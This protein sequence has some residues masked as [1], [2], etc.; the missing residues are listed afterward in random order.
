MTIERTDN[1]IVNSLDKNQETKLSFIS[2]SSMF[3]F[4]LIDSL[5]KKTCLDI[6]FSFIAGR[7]KTDIIMEKPNIKR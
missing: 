2:I 1:L 5:I 4:K 7:L 3:V 6:W